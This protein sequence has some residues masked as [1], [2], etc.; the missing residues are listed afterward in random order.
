M[1]FGAL[2]RERRKG[3][4]DS[5]REL[6]LRLGVTPAHI[7]D[8]ERGRRTPSA[9]LLE[10][11]SHE[12]D[13]NSTNHPAMLNATP[14]ADKGS[15]SAIFAKSRRPREELEEEESFIRNLLAA[16]ELG[17]AAERQIMQAG[18][19]RA[20]AKAL[21]QANVAYKSLYDTF[22]G[23]DLGPRDASRCLLV[24]AEWTRLLTNAWRNAGSLFPDGISTFIT[25]IDG[26]MKR[27]T[28]FLARFP[29]EAQ[30]QVSVVASWQ[31]L[32]TSEVLSMPSEAA[33]CSSTQ[34]QRSGQ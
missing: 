7:A 11:L 17:W 10:K 8:I 2:V 6:G 19:T 21:I 18:P 5:L 14:L 30:R 32:P 27:L 34:S 33:N 1:A 25:K 12:L 28:E 9:A 24:G 22:E 4:G 29:E 31:P 3:R 26:D 20:T 16:E 13:L 23:R 15:I